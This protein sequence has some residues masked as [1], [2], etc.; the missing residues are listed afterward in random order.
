MRRPMSAVLFDLDGVLVDSRLPITRSLRA[1]LA[2]HGAGDWPAQELERFIGPPLAEALS[3]LLDEPAGSDRI[4]A[5]VQTYRR[6][7]AVASLTETGVVDGIEAILDR[8]RDGPARLAVATSKPQ[9]YAEPLLDALGLTRFFDVVRGPGDGEE[10]VPKAHTVAEALRA[11]GRPE[12]AVMIG[13]RSHDIVGAHANRIPAIG[14]TWGIG[15]R[16]E[17]AQARAEA[18]IERPEQLPEALRVQLGEG[19]EY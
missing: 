11:L 18:I 13:D 17:L 12:R 8:L 7:Y 4:A 19:V 3:V 14:V 6:R 9:R 1:A 2:E 5:I 15:D 16:A 10:T